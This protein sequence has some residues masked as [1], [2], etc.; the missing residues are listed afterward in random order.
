MKRTWTRWSW[1]VAVA[2]LSAVGCRGVETPDGGAEQDAGPQDAGPGAQDA[3]PTALAVS[4]QPVD[5]TV[6]LGGAASFTVAATGGTSPYH[7]QWKRGTTAV[8]SDAA[9]LQLAAAAF[10]DVGSYTAT[11]TDSATPAQQVVSSAASLMV[12]APTLTITQQPQDVAV[13]AGASASLTVGVDGGVPPLTF[14]WKKGTTVVGTNSATLSFAAAQP[15]D[16]GS[17]TVTVSDSAPTAQQITS[18]AATVTVSTAGPAIASFAANPASVT[19]GSPSTLSWTTSGAN[20]WSIDHGVGAVTGPNGT[21]QVSPT[22]TTQYTLTAQGDGGTATAMATVTVMAPVITIAIQP[23]TQTLTRGTIADLHISGVSGGTRPYIVNLFRVGTTAPVQTWTTSTMSTFTY[24]SPPVTDA[25]NGAQFRFVITDSAMPANTTTSATATLTVI[26]FG[27][28]AMQPGTMVN[29]HYWHSATLLT[30]GKVM[31]AGGFLT[32]TT[33][34]NAELYDPATRTFS[35]TDGGLIQPRFLH[36]TVR[37]PNGKVLIAGGQ[38]WPSSSYLQSTELYDPATDRFAPG[39]TMSA[40]RAGGH[41]VTLLTVGPHAGRVLIAGGELSGPTSSYDLYDP[42][43]N[44]IVLSGTLAVDAGV[45]SF[46]AATRLLTGEVVVA[47]GISGTTPLDTSE[48]FGVDGGFTAAGPLPNNATQPHA[49][50]LPDGRVFL[51]GSGQSGTPTNGFPYV[52]NPTTRVW[53]ALSP[54]YQP[55][56]GVGPWYTYFDRID[57]HTV[58]LMTKPAIAGWV[59]VAGGN[60]GSSTNKA[61]LYDPIGNSPYPLRVLTQLR[62]G[63]TTTVLNDGSVIVIGGS[64]QGGTYWN[65]ADLYD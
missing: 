64:N 17:Y 15:T 33:G 12:T 5:V 40:Q 46:H 41:S 37:L 44:T 19:A 65:T 55:Y 10:T 18:R 53:T 23:W 3:G 30:T 8:G 57:N 61:Y 39:P 21:V 50:T 22:A 59:M 24:M 7:Y 47:G 43:T 28:A 51:I 62:Q 31:V 49:V 56:L 20:A 58:T 26:P 1:V 48:V 11:I 45:R 34:V 4:Q 29:G 35:A 25:D 9:T 36:Q 32:A 13:A 14:Q 52:M 6:A 60:R 38:A 54:T 63:H 16:T 27:P 42:T 2:A